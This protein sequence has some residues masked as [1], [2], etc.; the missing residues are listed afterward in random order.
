MF[1][2]FEHTAD[3]GLRVR[4]P[5][6]SRL[7]EEAATGL[8]SIL[9]VNLD[10][11][12]SVHE[13]T[14]H[15]VGDQLAFLLFDWLSE[16]LYTF[17]TEQLLVSESVVEINQTELHATCRGERMDLSKHQ[18]DHE[19]KAITYHRLNVEETLEG[20]WLAEIIVDI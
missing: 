7:F 19:V 11:V 2:I 10:D 15:I 18:M 1:E 8:F 16:L 20:D 17:E 6:L 3:L 13:K 9:V 4:S 12:E 14:Y 5:A